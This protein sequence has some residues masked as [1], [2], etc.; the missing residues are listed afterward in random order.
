MKMTIKDVAKAAGVSPSTVS[1]A[2]RNSSRISPEVRARVQRVAREMNFHPNQMARS[3]VS[4]RT[5]I[6]GVVFPGDLSMNLGNPFY[7]SVLQGI[8]H[9]ASERRH[10]VLLL[11]GSETLSPDESSRQAVESGYVSGLI[12]LAAEN[13]PPRDD[14][15]PVVVIGHPAQKCCAV[16]NDNVG[17]G[18]EAARHLLSHGHRRLLLAGY[19]PQYMFTVD[20]REGYERALREAGVPVDQTRVISAGTLFGSGEG[21][22]LRRLFEGPDRPTGVVCMDDAQAIGLCRQL[23]A[24]NLRVPRDVSVVSFNNTEASRYHNPPLTTFDIEP[25]QLGVKALN[26]LL[27]LLSGQV[28]APASLVVPFTL[29]QRQSVADYQ[30]EGVEP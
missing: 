12:R 11:T 29:V 5:P 24:M 27:D 8:G 22:T 16:D 23:D 21:E 18:Y 19:D 13:V 30:E 1:R 26:L 9:A 7:P 3:L 17:A 28:E 6:I 2:L 25:Y 15:V 10:H 14:E 4:R 20:R